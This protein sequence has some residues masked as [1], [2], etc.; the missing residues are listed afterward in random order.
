MSDLGCKDFATKKKNLAV[1]LCIQ[2]KVFFPYAF[3]SK[4]VKAK[5]ATR[6]V[7]VIKIR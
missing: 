4:A 1:F 6:S 5:E 3:I 2:Y 7:V